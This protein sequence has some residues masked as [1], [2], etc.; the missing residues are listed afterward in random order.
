[1]SDK[2]GTK[3][4]RWLDRLVRSDTERSHREIEVR[5]GGS[6]TAT[7][8]LKCAASSGRVS[9]CKSIVINELYNETQ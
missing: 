7:L 8:K 4:G 3:W 9:I 2:V 5:V 6:E 1:M